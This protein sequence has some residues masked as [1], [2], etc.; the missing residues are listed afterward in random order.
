MINQMRIYQVPVENRGPF[1]DRFRDHA[2]RIMARYNFRIQAM[3]TADTADQTR[4]VYLL[5]WEDEADMKAGWDAFMA[6]EEWPEIKRIT[7][8][9][10]GTM[11]LGIEDLILTPCDFSQAIG[12]ET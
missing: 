11:V 1:L 7:A 2:A 12:A 5:T 8:D 3:W 9:K 6:D 10:H 4:F